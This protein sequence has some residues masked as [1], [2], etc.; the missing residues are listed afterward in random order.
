M[1]D[2]LPL[3]I[4]YFICLAGLVL[5]FIFFRAGST[6]IITQ[7]RIPRL[8][9]AWITGYSLAVVGYSFQIMLNNPL[10]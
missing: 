1:K 6:L 10:A 9:L 8:L 7:V 5:I 4:L 2:K 3:I